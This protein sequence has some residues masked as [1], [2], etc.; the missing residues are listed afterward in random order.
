MLL[1]PYYAIIIILRNPLNLPCTI[2]QSY[3]LIQI[4]SHYSN[5]P[6]TLHQRFTDSVEADTLSYKT[7]SKYLRW[8]MLECLH[9]HIRNEKN[10]NVTQFYHRLSK[11]K[12]NSKAS[13]SC[14]FQ[15][16]KDCL[17]DYEGKTHV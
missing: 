5:T 7:G 14:C 11:K 8:I 13:R 15:V 10:S 9:A 3:F 1:F 17:L 16:G 4:P 12:G 6:D 2:S